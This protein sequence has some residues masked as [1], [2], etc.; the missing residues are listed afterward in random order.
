MYIPQSIGLQ[1]FQI[2]SLELLFI[3]RCLI[4]AFLLSLIYFKIQVRVY[5]VK[6]IYIY[7]LTGGTSEV[8][9]NHTEDPRY[10]GS[11]CYQ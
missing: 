1:N 5:Y 8:V 2:L 4:D 7:N 11:V 10:N 9:Q 6:Y 3:N